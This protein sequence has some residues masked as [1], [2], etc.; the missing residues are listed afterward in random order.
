MAKTS[1][2][3][4]EHMQA[5]SGNNHTSHVPMLSKPK[6][7]AAAIMDAAAKA[8]TESSSKGASQEF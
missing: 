5:P 4:E 6:E 7:A 3:M 1:T 2:F 8:T